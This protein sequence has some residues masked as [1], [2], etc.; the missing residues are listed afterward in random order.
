MEANS[1]NM[2]AQVQMGRDLVYLNVYLKDYDP[3]LEYPLI[4]MLHG[5]GASMYDLA[6]L[7]PV[8]EPRGY[9][10]V[11][12]NGPIPVQVA[13]GALAFSWNIPGG[14]DP[15]QTR[16][17]EQ[18]L[19]GFLQEVMEQYP[20][21]SGRSLLLGFSQG[22]G[23][24]YRFGLTNPGLFAGLVAFSC[25][26]RDPEGIR[27]LLPEQRDQSIFIAHGLQDNP[28]RARASREFLESQ[29]Y[30]PFYKEY[31]MGHEINREVLDDL[32]PWIRRVLPPLTRG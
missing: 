8:I 32:V 28:E 6:N 17:C 16:R 11:C 3:S 23:L 24:T 21:A 18:K 31:P 25:S 27:Q 30:S 12:P 4:I 5:F 20:G 29:G 19:E 1:Q 26:L 13:E 2:R 15:E 9:L 14:N 10:Y 22:G 7:A